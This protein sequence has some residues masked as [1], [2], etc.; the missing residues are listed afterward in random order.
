MNLK[1]WMGGLKGVLERLINTF[2]LKTCTLLCYNQPP[3]RTWKGNMSGK[4]H[5]YGRK[6]IVRSRVG[7]IEVF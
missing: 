2:L 4:A 1:I 5:A 3:P 6:D 7:V